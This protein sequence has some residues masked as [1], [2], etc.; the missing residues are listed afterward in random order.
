[1]SAKERLAIQRALQRVSNALNNPTTTEL[2]WQDAWVGVKGIVVLNED[3]AV[4][5]RIGLEKRRFDMLQTLVA[6]GAARPFKRTRT[7]NETAVFARLLVEIN[8]RS[9]E[10]LRIMMREFLSV[11][12]LNADMREMLY[13]NAFT[14]QLGCVFAL[15]CAE[16]VILDL[17]QTHGYKKTRD[18]F[19][20]NKGF[21]ERRTARWRLI[22]FWLLVKKVIVGWRETLYEPGTGA[23]YK[24]ALLSFTGDN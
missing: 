23:L 7:A 8:K 3:I 10:R 11:C 24:K 13:V 1:M 20:I 17:Y 15:R 21:R 6:G 12:R 4:W 9:T 19:Y 18:Y 5:W 16:P 22:R 2:M 14:T